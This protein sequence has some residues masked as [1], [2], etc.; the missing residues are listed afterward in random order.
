MFVRAVRQISRAAFVHVT[1]RC[2]FPRRRQCRH[3]TVPGRGDRAPGQSHGRTES[4]PEADPCCRSEPLALP[5]RAA[6]AHTAAAPSAGECR[7]SSNTRGGARARRAIVSHRM[8]DRAA[9]GRFFKKTAQDAAVG[10]GL[11]R[12]DLTFG[13]GT[14]SQVAWLRH[15]D[16]HV[17]GRVALRQYRCPQY[18]YGLTKMA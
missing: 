18:L 11:C 1:G 17:S 16:D 6:G 2:A 9:V 14:G 15:S 7:E 13:L 12:G 8:H 4:L 5:R 3:R 10:R